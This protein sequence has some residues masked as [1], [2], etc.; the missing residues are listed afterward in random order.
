[1]SAE[2]RQSW[3][4]D[5]PFNDSD[6]A[7]LL[8]ASFAAVRPIS[9]RI[10]FEN[11]MKFVCLHIEQLSEGFFEISRNGAIEK[12]HPSQREEHTG[13]PSPGKRATSVIGIDPLYV[14]DGDTHILMDTEL[15]WG[16]DH[17]SD[18]SRNSN[19][20]TNLDIFGIDTEKI[21]FVVL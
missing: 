9:C 3:R 11:C 2:T 5:S 19:V 20:R 10:S 8:G 13:T 4:F 6:D 14:T 15:G 18:Y 16:L 21:N 17:A 1:M 7:Y 12:I